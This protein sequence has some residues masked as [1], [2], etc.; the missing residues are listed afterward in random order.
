MAPGKARDAEKERQ[1]RRWIAQWQTSGS[2]VTAFCARHGLSPASFYAWRKTLRRR[3][4][5]RTAFVPV[6]V[7]A[8]LAAAPARPL[9]VVLADGRVVRVAPGFDA[10]T[11]RQLL[12]VLREDQPC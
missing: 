10:A 1:W 3:D 7:V 8:D 6:H 2:S 4:A 9:E 5:E 11:L 12:A